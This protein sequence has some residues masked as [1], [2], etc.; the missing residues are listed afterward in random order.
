MQASAD[1]TPTQRADIL[2]R[3]RSAA[4]RRAKYAQAKAK[5]IRAGTYLTDGAAVPT[6]VP[7]ETPSGNRFKY[8]GKE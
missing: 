6:S 2:N 7:P 4:E 1:K 8:I 3:A 5:A